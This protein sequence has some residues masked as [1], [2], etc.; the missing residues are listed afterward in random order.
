MR[1]SSPWPRERIERRSAG[2]DG[3]RAGRRRACR[4]PLEGGS[5]SAARP[6]RARAR[7]P[8]R[9]TSPSRSHGESSRAPERLRLPDVPDP[10]DERW[11]SS[12]SPSSRPWCS[13]RRFATIEAEVGRVGED[14]RP[15]ASGPRLVSSSTGPFQSTASRSAPRE[16]EP[17]LA[18]LS[19]PRSTTCQRPLM[20][21][22]LRRTRPPSKRS[23][24]FLPTASTASSLRPSSRSAE[25]AAAARGSA[26]RPPR[27]RRPG[28]A[29][30]GPRG[31]GRRPRAR[32]EV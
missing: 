17:R 6:R 16:H 31:G 14:V 3:R 15:E 28:P 19:A 30:G 1:L 22:W 12:A 10:R 2:T 23:S 4:R 20:R 24:R 21:R 25:T 8:R 26:S 7:A 27:A 11:S 9:S 18:V 13:R 29:G 5:A 32:V